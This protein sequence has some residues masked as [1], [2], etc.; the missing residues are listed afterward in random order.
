[1]AESDSEII[2]A[3]RDLM[4]QQKLKMTDVAKGINIPY[5]SLQNY[6]AKRSPMPLSVYIDVCEWIGITPDYLAKGRFKL[7]HHALQRAIIEVFGEELFN[8]IDFDDHMRWTIGP[9]R[10]LDRARLR[11]AAGAI[12]GWIEGAYGQAR[13][14]GKRTPDEE[15]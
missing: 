7:D 12:A 9:K 4:T 1:M 8:S 10:E 2:D 11:R 14:I 5:R 13:E 15:D 3:L 6:M